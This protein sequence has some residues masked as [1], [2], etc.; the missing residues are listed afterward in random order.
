M[1]LASCCLAGQI[2]VWDA[3]TGDCLTV[4][5]KTLRRSSSSSGCWDQRDGWD[6][7][8]TGPESDCMCSESQ[9]LSMGAEVPSED[10]GYPVRRRSTP[11]RTALFADQPDLTPLIDTNFSSQQEP[12]ACPPT[13]PRGGFDFGGLVERAYQEYDPPSPSAYPAPSPS[14]VSSSPPTGAGVL[15]QG[16]PAWERLQPD[17]PPRT[18]Q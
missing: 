17:I 2:R 10:E 3:Q 4:I 18:E 11:V 5:P 1:L 16:A 13:P 12:S 7:S 15:L 9:E 14:S 8:T 6:S